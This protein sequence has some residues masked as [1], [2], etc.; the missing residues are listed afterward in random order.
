MEQQSLP[1]NQ[2]NDDAALFGAVFNHITQAALIVNDHGRIYRANDAAVKLLRLSLQDLQNRLLWEAGLEGAKSVWPQ[3]LANEHHRGQHTLQFAGGELRSVNCRV[4]VNVIPN[5]HLI[6]L[7][8]LPL[9]DGRFPASPILDDI[10]PD[11]LNHSAIG[12][13]TADLNGRIRRVNQAFCQM[14]GYTPSEL[15]G[16]SFETI[17]HAEDVPLER[18]KANQLRTGQ[19]DNYQLRKRYLHKE[20]RIV[21]GLLTLSLI[22]NS[23][24]EPDY[25][26]GQIQDVTPW[27][28]AEEQVR[29]SEAE[30][31]LLADNASDLI[32][33]FRPDGACVYVSP[34]V[35]RI[36]GYEPEEF[37]GFHYLD[38][39]HPDD[40]EKTIDTMQSVDRYGWIDS[41]QARHR[42]KDGR[43]RW[44]DTTAQLVQDENDQPL[45]LVCISRDVTVR[46]EMIAAL[47][48]SERRFR[49]LYESSPIPTFLWQWEKDEFTLVGMNSAAH[50]TAAGKGWTFLGR[51]ATHIYPDRPDIRDD[52]RRCLEAKTVIRRETEYAT[53]STQR[54]RRIIF[55]LSYVSPNQ[56]MMHAEDITTRWQTEQS[57]RKLSQTVE[58]SPVSVIITDLDGII[59][60]VNPH[61]TQVTGYTEEEAL[62]QNPRL[63]SSG[64]QDDGFYRELWETITAGKIWRGEFLNR[65]KD[66]SLFWESASISPIKNQNGQITHYVAVKEDITARKRLAERVQQQD[67]LAALGQLAAGI[68]HDFNNILAVLMLYTQ[69]WQIE[70]S[71]IQDRS[72]LD[73]VLEQTRR[74]KELIQQILDFS[75]RSVLKKQPIDLTLLINKESKLLRR[76]LPEHITVNFIRNYN[77]TESPL[78]V[79]ADLTRLQQMLLNLSVNARDAMPVGGELR[80]T[81]A[82]HT[83]SA[84]D[85]R[86]LPTMPPGDWI[87]LT[88]A[89]NGKGIP[90]EILSHIFDP[91]YTTKT[92]DR[93]TG[94]GLAQVYGIVKQHGGYIDVESEVGEGTTFTIYLPRLI[95][96][97]LGGE[98]DANGRLVSGAGQCILVVE[99]NAT[100]RR[101]LEQGLITLGYR[102]VMAENGH[103]AMEILEGGETAVDLIL[104]DMVMPHMG[105]IELL[106]QLRSHNYNLPVIILSGYPLSADVDE[107]KAKG[108]TAWLSKP[109]ELEQLAQSIAAHLPSKDNNAS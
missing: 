57:L 30:Y 54:K 8:P 92:P 95:E 64:Y 13:A 48:A 101:A 77:A 94:L 85:T 83:F 55:T 2:S 44:L 82:T 69:L 86:P 25:F 98:D 80:F 38:I 49:T 102:V 21:W 104:S 67:K 29:R 47:T 56:V 11:I 72:Q 12:M 78:K 28:E 108:M 5:Y 19:T 9:P 60:Y 76:T 31:R 17:T 106:Q 63:L 93:G 109:P 84:A 24:G 71:S 23:D 65:K 33:R 89:D 46:K 61:F 105:G 14:L 87:Q 88:I 20:G 37:V 58:Q 53:R 15:I 43:Y 74:A 99:D 41:V 4:K 81:L 91:F 39:I 7:D 36:L 32:T 66:G 10:F 68:A 40:R 45:E 6:I 79:H 22:T 34:S 52:L 27:V 59:E 42:T 70:E 103:E 50:N 73:T 1:S 18:E 96:P 62:G 107:L 51:D 97:A 100:T 75:R 3:I 16:R 35:K 26:L 90:E